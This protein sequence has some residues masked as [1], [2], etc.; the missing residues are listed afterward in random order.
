MA[1]E[2][3]ITVRREKVKRRLLRGMSTSEIAK[4]LSKGGRQ[5]SVRT[6]QL[7]IQSIREEGGLQLS[8][9][10]AREFI[11]M[12]AMKQDELERESWFIYHND[13]ATSQDKLQALKRIQE[14]AKDR[15]EMYQAIGLIPAMGGGPTVNVA[16]GVNMERCADCPY[17]SHYTRSE[18]K[19]VMEV[20]DNGSEPTTET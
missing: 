19:A 16:V 9:L 2:Q 1:N 3:A 5:V 7:D 13:E 17:K 20:E 11:A 12:A 8:K 14:I 6:I 4:A 10:D 15:L 18:I